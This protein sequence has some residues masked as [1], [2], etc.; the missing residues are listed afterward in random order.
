MITTRVGCARMTMR[1]IPFECLSQFLCQ[2][3]AYYFTQNLNRPNI[4]IHIVHPRQPAQP[5]HCYLKRQENSGHQTQITSPA[6][7]P[8]QSQKSQNPCLKQSLSL[9]DQCI[10]ATILHSHAFSPISVFFLHG[11]TVRF[12]VDTSLTCVNMIQLQQ[13]DLGLVSA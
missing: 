11:T 7:N 10:F 2:K 8:E 1:T 5:T 6:K 9:T 12:P 4:A 3:P 13:Q